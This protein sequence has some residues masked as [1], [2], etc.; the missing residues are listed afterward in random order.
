MMPL[1]LI[2]ILSVLTHVYQIEGKLTMSNL[3]TTLKKVRHVCCS[4]FRTLSLSFRILP[5]SLSFRTELSLFQN[6]T[7]S[8]SFRI[9]PFSL[10]QIFFCLAFFRRIFFFLPEPFLSFFYFFQN[11]FFLFSTSF[12]TL[13]ICF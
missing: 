11:S 12:R 8:L 2:L 9:L 13:S 4:P 5:F 10:F 1:L 6:R 7:L 3:F